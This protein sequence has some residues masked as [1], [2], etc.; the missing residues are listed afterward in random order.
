M[1]LDRRIP[2]IRIKT[3]QASELLGKRIVVNIDAWDRTSRFPIGHFVRTLGELETKQAETE[4]ILLEHDVQYRPFPKSVLDCLPSEGH[5]WRVPTDMSHPGWKGRKDLRHL[6]VCSIDPP[7]CQDIDDALHARL[8]S[9][10]NY[11]VG[12]HIADVS[13]FVKPNNAMDEEAAMRGTTVY[14]VDKRIDM[15]P[16]LL[17]TDLCSLKPYV[18]RFAFSAIWVCIM[19]LFYK[20]LL[21][22]GRK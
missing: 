19:T 15:L 4:A 13:N 6:L 22:G 7:K 12:V 11:E 20:D 3:R 21:I 14:L 5:D 10:G 9:N 1:A 2:R 8:L 17:G 18:E 16:P